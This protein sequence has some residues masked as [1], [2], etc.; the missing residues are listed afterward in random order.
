[1]AGDD[2]ISIHGYFR[3]ILLIFHQFNALI[4]RNV[5][6]LKIRQLNFTNMPVG[7]KFEGGEEFGSFNLESDLAIKGI[8]CSRRNEDLIGTCLHLDELKRLLLETYSSSVV[9]NVLMGSH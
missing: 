1:M 5:K 6:N 7:P 4:L 2:V 8:L 3:E 9:E